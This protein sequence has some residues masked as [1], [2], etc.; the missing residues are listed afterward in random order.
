MPVPSPADAGYLLMPSS[1]SPACSR[2]T[3]ADGQRVPVT[4]PADGLT[5][6]LAIGAVSAAIVFQTARD[7]L[8]RLSADRDAPWPIQSAT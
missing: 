4:L 1:C 6:A 3:G 2:S 5:A 8:R 7:G